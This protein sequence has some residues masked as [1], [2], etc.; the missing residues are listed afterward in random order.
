MVIITTLHARVWVSVLET[1][2]ARAGSIGRAPLAKIWIW[3]HTA[4]H[5]ALK[6]VLLEH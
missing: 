3:A 5:S 2:S 4:H 6:T 1:L